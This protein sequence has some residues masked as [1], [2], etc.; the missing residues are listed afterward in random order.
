M[1]VVTKELMGHFDFWHVLRIPEMKKVRPSFLVGSA[2]TFTD[3]PSITM[4]QGRSNFI[5][6]FSLKLPEMILIIYPS[7]ILVVDLVTFT[8]EIL[9]EKLHFL[10]SVTCVNPPTVNVLL[11]K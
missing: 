4:K 2:E 11:D 3:M 9:N 7:I 5:F 10:C 6:S 1:I 8:G